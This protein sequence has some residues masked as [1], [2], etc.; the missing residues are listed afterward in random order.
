MQPTCLIC[1]Q[2][3][4]VYMPFLSLENKMA[5]KYQ[6]FPS[7]VHV[8]MADYFRF[9][10]CRT[11][12]TTN[13]H[14]NN[15]QIGM[16]KRYQGWFPSIPDSCSLWRCQWITEFDTIDRSSHFPK[17]KR[18]TTA[19]VVQSKSNLYTRADVRTVQRSLVQRKGVRLIRLPCLLFPSKHGV[20]PV[21]QP[22]QTWNTLKIQRIMNAA[23]YPPLTASMCE[24]IRS[25]SFLQY[26]WW[27]LVM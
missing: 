14:K 10:Y 9:L 16:K 22:R 6:A 27:K 17:N 21:E 18:E 7:E 4:L 24:I 25:T 5:S 19:R 3:P 15:T 23:V 26:H 20:K 1:T 11:T 13:N 2:G 12:G 8:N